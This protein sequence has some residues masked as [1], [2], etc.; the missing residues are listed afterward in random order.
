MKKLTTKNGKN[1]LRYE[2]SSKQ[3][4][5]K[6]FSRGTRKNN[7]VYIIDNRYRYLQRFRY[8]DIEIQMYYKQNN[9][10][11][12][13]IKYNTDYIIT[14]ILKIKTIVVTRILINMKKQNL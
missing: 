4:K 6:I 5:K 11:M 10:K 8:L 1:Q 2:I 9:K 3:I 12:K 14:I 7:R 13:M